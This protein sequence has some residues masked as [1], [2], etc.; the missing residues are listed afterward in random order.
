MRVFVYFY[1]GMVILVIGSGGVIEDWD[2]C[3]R[4]GWLGGGGVGNFFLER[5]FLI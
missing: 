1:F 2:S 5:M 4:N 3:D